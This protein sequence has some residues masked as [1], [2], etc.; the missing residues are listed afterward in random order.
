M[1]PGGER[2]L[3]GE[4]GLLGV[5]VLVGVGGPRLSRS[6]DLGVGYGRCPVE[7]LRRI[8]SYISQ[9]LNTLSQD[10]VPQRLDAAK[11]PY[12]S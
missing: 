10:L 3:V 6:L 2:V 7:L 5:G 8:L 12:R 1:G 11:V 4:E 9:T